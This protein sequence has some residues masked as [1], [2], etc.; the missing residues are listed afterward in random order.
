MGKWEWAK[1]D[2]CIVFVHSLA[3]TL[4]S[5]SVADLL[6]TDGQQWERWKVF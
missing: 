6:W 5:T 3:I 1:K 4:L 2:K